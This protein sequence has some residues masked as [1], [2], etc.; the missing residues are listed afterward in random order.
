MMSFLFGISCSYAEEYPPPPKDFHTLTHSQQTVWR[1]IDA[2]TP[3]HY[4]CAIDEHL[5]PKPWTLIRCYNRLPSSFNAS[6][7][8]LDTGCRA[9]LLFGHKNL[10]LVHP[11]SVGSCW[12]QGSVQARQVLLH[13]VVH[14]GIAVWKPERSFPKLLP[15]KLEAQHLNIRIEI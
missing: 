6:H 7:K 4:S 14:D 11:K 2:E 13:H 15:A 10:I 8:I 5:I 3:T 9:L 1:W 12:C